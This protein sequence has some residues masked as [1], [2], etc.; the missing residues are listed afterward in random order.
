LGAPNISIFGKNNRNVYYE[1]DI[2]I[3]FTDISPQVS[4]QTSDKRIFRTSTASIQIDRNSNPIFIIGDKVGWPPTRTYRNEYNYYQNVPY[5]NYNYS[6]DNIFLTSLIAHKKNANITEVFPGAV[7]LELGKY[8]N[9]NTI[10]SDLY[11]PFPG[12]PV[13]DVNNLDSQLKTIGV[14]VEPTGVNN[15]NFTFISA[16]YGRYF[17]RSPTYSVNNLE[18]V[19]HSH[20]PYYTGALGTTTLQIIPDLSSSI[21]FDLI[22]YP[23]NYAY[24]Y[25]Y[26][27]S[28][29]NNYIS[30][31]ITITNYNDG[32]D[33]LNIS[34]PV[35]FNGSV[36]YERYELSGDKNNNLFIFKNGSITHNLTYNQAY[37]LI[38]NI[39][40]HFKGLYPLGPEN[41]QPPLAADIKYINNSLILDSNNIL[42]DHNSMKIQSPRYYNDIV[43]N[44]IIN[45]IIIDT[46]NNLYIYE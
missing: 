6:L 5:N 15:P 33:L 25:A 34:S 43:F 1:L 9:L 21:Y 27:I 31:S 10:N 26:K 3:A 46:N 42:R 11:L 38:F 8:V 13:L 12:G 30:T 7:G 36:Y 20:T 22:G 28:D 39:T 4:G 29:I 37:S 19:I 41:S 24:N 35:I 17:S 18:Y 2:P 23:Y 32:C 45:N 40:P 44:K 14:A 16:I